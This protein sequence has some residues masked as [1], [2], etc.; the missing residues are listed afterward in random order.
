MSP[1]PKQSEELDESSSLEGDVSDQDAT[2]EFNEEEETENQPE[3]QE[4]PEAPSQG[5]S[6]APLQ[7][8]DL[9]DPLKCDLHFT[10]SMLRS[11]GDPAGRQV[12]LGARNDNDDPII[13]LVR[14]HDLESLFAPLVDLYG[15]LVAD[16]PRRQATMQAR[17]QEI[18]KRQQEAAKQ[19]AARLKT[20]SKP[21]E[22][23]ASSQVAP[24]DQA[25]PP[26]PAATEKPLDPPR[27]QT[28]KRT[29]KPAEGESEIEQ[30]TLF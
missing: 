2:E 5:E 24:S 29:T 11:D 3:E 10:I 14:A 13:S 8:P 20:S 6:P 18:Q 26:A 28:A 27:K 21:K 19:Q 4:Q 22:E 9:Y 12:L 30:M 25:Q 15:R 16:L 7:A 17:L 1:V 23:K